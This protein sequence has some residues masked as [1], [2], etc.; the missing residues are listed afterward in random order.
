MQNILITITTW[1]M[2]SKGSS[3]KTQKTLWLDL[4][5]WLVGGLLRDKWQKNTN[6]KPNKCLSSTMWQIWTTQCL[7]IHLAPECLAFPC[8][9]SVFWISSSCS[10]VP[11]TRHSSLLYFAHPVGTRLVS[12]RAKTCPTHK[13]SKLKVWSKLTLMLCYKPVKAGMDL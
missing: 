1:S 8:R 2:N 10:V 5:C 3:R 4:L 7:K 13:W 12:T 11:I 6:A 9:G